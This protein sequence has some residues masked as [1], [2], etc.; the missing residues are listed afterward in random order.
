[1]SDIAV[2]V[3]N[4][5]PQVAINIDGNS[6][7]FWPESRHLSYRVDVQDAEDGEI[8]KGVDVQFQFDTSNDKH[9]SKNQTTKLYE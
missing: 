1:M 2:E 9:E 4:T 5:P 6:S 8:Q 3:G 7:F